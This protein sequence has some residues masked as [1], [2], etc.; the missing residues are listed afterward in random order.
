MKIAYFKVIREK[1]FT[2]K[3]KFPGLTKFYYGGRDPQ[4]HKLLGPMK[5]IP[6]SVCALS[7]L[8]AL[9]QQTMA[10]VPISLLPVFVSMC[11]P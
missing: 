10:C 11:C 9:Y 1:K 3:I 6:R 5:V 4:R 2:L 7:W 8:G